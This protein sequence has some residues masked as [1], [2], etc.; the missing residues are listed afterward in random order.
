MWA[1]NQRRVEV[2][3]LL[4]E[5]GADQLIKNQGGVTAVDIAKLSGSRAVMGLLN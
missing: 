5:A 1:A 4:L 3:Q 2:V